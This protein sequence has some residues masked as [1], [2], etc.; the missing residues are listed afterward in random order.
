M[1]KL[2]KMQTALVDNRSRATDDAIRDAD[3]DDEA[4][5]T[6]QHEDLAQAKEDLKARER[7]LRRCCSFRN[8]QQLAEAVKALHDA[9]KLAV[10]KLSL[11]SATDP[12]ALEC[13][14][15]MEELTDA[16][17]SAVDRLDV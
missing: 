9:T 7:Q 5:T 14:V 1:E 13:L 11:T 4:L 15:K 2:A 16:A 17:E 8:Y 6:E 3:V 10:T 12:A